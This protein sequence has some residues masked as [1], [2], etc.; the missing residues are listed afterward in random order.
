MKFRKG[1]CPWVDRSCP[2]EC[3]VPSVDNFG[4]PYPGCALAR[5]KSMAEIEAELQIARDAL[6]GGGKT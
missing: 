5:L 6:K 4:N 3:P 1:W 2:S